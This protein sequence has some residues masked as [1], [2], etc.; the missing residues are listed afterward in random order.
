M[1]A[2]VDE[3]LETREFRG[4]PLLLRE[5]LEACS[6]GFDACDIWIGVSLFW[7]EPAL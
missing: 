2:I 6:N 4:G 5:Y 1:L 3:C 7:K